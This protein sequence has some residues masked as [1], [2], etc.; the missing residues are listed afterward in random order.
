LRTAK[1]IGVVFVATLVE[2]LLLL[3]TIQA[4]ASTEKCRNGWDSPLCSGAA[5]PLLLLALFAVA[6]WAF[7]VSRRIARQRPDD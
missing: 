2:A 4:G 3:S 5:A 7:V 6:V 1:I